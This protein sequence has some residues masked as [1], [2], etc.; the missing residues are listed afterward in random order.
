MVFRSLKLLTNFENA[1]RIPPQKTLLC[2]WLMLSIADLSMAAE[3][4][5]KH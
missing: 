5:P 1:Y 2:D 4:M 3:K